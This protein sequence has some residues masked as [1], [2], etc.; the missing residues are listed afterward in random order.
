MLTNRHSI[1]QSRIWYAILLVCSLIASACAPAA[2]PAG[3]APASEAAA[4]AGE[5]VELEMWIPSWLGDELT[6][7][8]FQL[9][10]FMEQ[11]PEVTVNIIRVPFD[12]FDEKVITAAMGGVLP[13]LLEG[14]HYHIARFHRW[15]ILESLENLKV[16][17][18][19]AEDNNTILK[20]FLP[21]ALDSTM[22]PD[23]SSSERLLRAIPWRRYGCTPKYLS[24]A[25][26][27]NGDYPEEAHQL[28]E[29]LTRV[30]IQVATFADSKGQTPG[31]WPTRI[32]A[33]QQLQREGV[34]CPGSEAQVHRLYSLETDAT[35]SFINEHIGSLEAKIAGEATAVLFLDDQARRQI[36]Y[37][38]EDD[39]KLERIKANI[40]VAAVP[41]VRTGDTS[42]GPVDPYLLQQMKENFAEE[43]AQPGSATVGAL[44]IQSE[45]EG[46]PAGDYIVDCSNAGLSASDLSC[47]TIDANNS[48]MDIGGYG[49]AAWWEDTQSDGGYPIATYETSS[50]GRICFNID[51]RRCCIGR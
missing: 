37:S 9:K 21:D 3:G 26:P 44:L 20:N 19:D 10:Q 31:S 1:V 47:K 49:L 41:V 13:D 46:I 22:F 2:A 11:N 25:R 43:L 14:T 5:K 32:E 35:V 36:E 42:G 6:I 34:I 17:W 12:E 30:D 18:P 16:I 4:P 15:G 23:A 33:Y 29:F 7:P 8:E 39:T 51:G 27:K 40:Q 48:E 24:L 38:G 50:P 45:W 28:I